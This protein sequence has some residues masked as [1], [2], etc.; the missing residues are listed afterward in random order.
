M[1]RIELRP[2]PVLDRADGGGA[3]LSALPVLGSLGSIGLVATMAGGP[4]QYAGIALFVAAA[5][6]IAVAQVERQ[7]RQRSRSID[8]ARRDYLAHLADVRTRLRAAGDGQ[9]AAALARHPPPAALAALVEGG[10]W[11]PG[12]G[13]QVRYGA[14]DLPL[15][16][17]PTCPEIGARA[18]PFCAA[19]VR[20]LVTAFE[21]WPA[22]PAT[23][24]LRGTRVLT[25]PA[26]LAR[27][28][29]CSAALTPDV[30]IGV[31]A[32]TEAASRWEWVKWLP[33]SAGRV[34][35]G[36]GPRRL[37]V[38]TAEVLSA[39]APE[40]RH[41]LLVADGVPPPAPGPA[42]TV[43]AVAGRFTVDGRTV[44]GVADDCPTEV[45]EAFGRRL[46]GRAP[47]LAGQ[48]DWSPRPPGDRLTVVIGTSD[49][50]AD[51]RLDLK[52]AALG[53]HGPHGAVIGATGSGKS[54]L[55][56]AMVLRLALSHPPAELNLVLIDFK[57]GAA[58]DG[59][60]GL[61]HVSALITNLADELDLLGRTAEALTSELTRR[62][63]LIRAADGDRGGLPTLLVVVDE[64]A[65][66]LAARPD[67]D[68]LFVTIGRLGRGLGI[69]LL[70]ACQRLDEGRWR[71]LES[72]LS[73]RIG[74]R[75]FTAEES[76]A[77]LGVV[78]AYELPASPGL[79]YLRTDPRTLV[80]FRAPYVGT[81]LRQPPDPHRVLPFTAAPVQGPPPR[82][83]PVVD[84][85]VAVMQGRGSA[86]RIWLPPLDVPATLGDLLPEVAVD[87]VRGFGVPRA[88]VP[89]GEIDRPSRQ[90]RDLLEVDLTAGHVAIVGTTGSGRSTL[91]RTAVAGLAVT[92]TPQEVAV[93]LLDLGGA[94]APLA[95]LP[96][97]TARAGPD[98]PELA[99][100]MV[101][102]LR[103]GHRRPTLLVVDDW[104][105][106]R[107]H[108]P[109]VEEDV[110]LLAAH[111]RAS[112]VHLLVTT[113]RWTDLRAAVRDLFDTRL[114][115]RLADPLDSEVD[116]RL[117]AAVPRDRPGRGIV[118]GAHFLAAVPRLDTSTDARPEARPAARSS[119]RR[120]ET[121]ADAVLTDLV[122]A[123]RR[124][125]PGPT[126]P[127]L[128]ALPATV[129]LG[130]LPAAA[131]VRLGICEGDHAVLTLPPSGHLV[132]LGDD[133]SGRT[134]LLR[135]IVHEVVRAHPAD[136]IVFLDPRATLAGR[137][138]DRS[139]HV[140]G[141]PTA[142]LAVVAEQL[143]GMLT[144]MLTEGPA[145]RQ[146]PATSTWVLADDVDL[147]PATA[148]QPILPVLA[149][150]AD[151]GLR[152][153]V[154]RRVGGAGRAFYEPLL[155]TLR[156][157]GSP[158]VILSGSAEEGPLV[159]GVPARP[160]DPG[161]ARWARSH[162]EPTVFQAAYLDP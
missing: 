31:L 63:E 8:A 129:R 115:L 4:R 112:G 156:E 142:A 75:T 99:A 33:H 74:L 51:V 100:R 6:L 21:T 86:H 134:S 158:G 13:R 52:E 67:L 89:L 159:T 5:V 125:W 139:I 122:E 28:L 111:G 149:R 7:R 92:R 36:V 69:H 131:G 26:G 59:L 161:R 27:A 145:A 121:S 132:V 11:R 154:S 147:A 90:R 58:F 40:G 64:F 44:P 140:T 50:G 104:A 55:L 1:D 23:V 9:R 95:G 22:L 15:E 97:V 24:D 116:R 78:D 123:V 2:P 108:L 29:V 85:C 68:E 47:A 43:I 87:P 12:G 102:E 155:A 141:D 39:L 138:P 105:A 144:G 143:T 124:H 101:R 3:L 18:D 117:A 110:A 135:T 32:A 103:R 119:Q 14:A 114:E 46:A 41:L 20:R 10:A 45:A 76:R 118:D 148:W 17:A 53:G 107:C 61:P 77:V 80:R 133:G 19:A 98:E 106:L 73:Y 137:L 162:H 160:A 81:V 146:A 153:V 150:S 62:Q 94:L 16:R 109:D 83:V 136:R 65:E 35:D 130:E 49:T 93:H 96:H 127:R 151:V 152:L 70:V 113:G 91:L 30:A 128:R 120:A 56:R 37:V 48:P 84:A 79:G 42:M 57:G 54:E 126:Q 82:P 38:G 25:A 71:G 88:T 66:L 60:T 157:L 34:D 72:H